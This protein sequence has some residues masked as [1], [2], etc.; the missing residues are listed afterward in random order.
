LI[1]AVNLVLWL[2]I[3]KLRKGQSSVAGVLSS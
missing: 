1:L 2:M 3:S